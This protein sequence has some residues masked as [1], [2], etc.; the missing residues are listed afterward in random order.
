MLPTAAPSKYE[1]GRGSTQ[2]RLQKSH[3]APRGML[4]QE[5]GPEGAALTS[6]PQAMLSTMKR[7]GHR[8]ALMPGP[9]GC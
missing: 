9:K 7:A 2:L 4:A 1:K 3:P 6:G 5:E 8:S